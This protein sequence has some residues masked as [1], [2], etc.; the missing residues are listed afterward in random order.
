M[1]RII[2]LISFCL[3]FITHSKNASAQYYFYDDDYYDSPFLFEVGASLGAMNCFTDIGGAKGVGKRFVKDLNLGA[4]SF[5]GGIFINAMYKN[6]V[7]LRLEGTF[8]QISANDNVLKDVDPKD[9]AFQRYN[10]NTSFRSKIT[11]ISLVTELHPLFIF[12]DYMER[13]SDP[14][15]LSPYLLAGV[16]YYTFNPQTEL[17]GKWIDLQPL[18]TEGQGFKEYPDRK[19]YKLQQLS[20]PVGLGIKYE[21]SRMVN[22]R[23]EFVYRVLQTDYLDDMSTTYVDPTLYSNYFTGSKLANALILSDR[24]ITKVTG[25][26]G[27]RGSPKQKDSFFSINLKLSLTIGRQKIR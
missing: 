22:L 16:G 7:A 8:G 18:S 10:R 12:I 4:T 11:E 6:A 24:Q 21:L 14:P 2:Y 3:L 5:A 17:N 13:E 27:K 25:P 23:G 20:I 1:K 9:I 26:G 19:V 15:K